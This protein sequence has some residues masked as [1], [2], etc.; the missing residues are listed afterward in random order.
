[1]RRVLPFFLVAAFCATVG[2]APATK[3]PKSKTPKPYQVGSASWYGKKFHG[4]TTASGEP[5]DMFQ[6]T[7]AHR[8]LPLGTW[9]RVTNLRNGRW[10]MVRVNDRGPVPQTRIIDLSYGAAS[11]LQLRHKGVERVR[12]DLIQPEM[13]A[14]N[15][16]IMQ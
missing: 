7:A 15:R 5:Y 3:G 8:Q 10:V 2:A 11:L 12:L 6:L 16:Q 1:M 4:R 14:S 13:L 9:L